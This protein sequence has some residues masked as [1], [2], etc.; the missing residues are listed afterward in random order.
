MS[1]TIPV[2]MKDNDSIYRL[3]NIIFEDDNSIYFCFP[4]KGG[5]HISRCNVQLYTGLEHEGDYNKKS[6]I[7]LNKP[8]VEFDTAKISFHPR[9]MIAHVIDKNGKRLFCDVQLT[10]M[11]ENQFVVPFIQIV[12]PNDLSVLELY[13]KTKYKNVFQLDNKL[14]KNKTL[15]L[16]IYIHDSNIFIDENELFPSKRKLL[17]YETYNSN[18]K[19][20]CTV[21]V[22]R[23]NTKN[24]SIIT[25]L[26]GKNAIVISAIEKK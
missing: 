12:I 17:F 10:S 14:K 11:Y 4:N 23:I 13:N 8:T 9:D 7:R 15:S 24:D 26:N 22:S 25:V 18:Y 16:E 20:T 21:F 3:A 1:E 5:N 6:H 2:L 19:Y